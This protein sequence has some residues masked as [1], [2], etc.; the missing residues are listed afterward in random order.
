M[1]T[2]VAAA[3]MTSTAN[4]AENLDQ[5]EWLIEQA[6]AAKAKLVS[7]P[8][9]F[10]FIGLGDDAALNA[11]EAIDGATIS[12][13]QK[14][15]KKNAIWLSLGGFQEK[16]AGHNK[17]YNT[18]II[19]NNDGLL[20]ATYRKIHLFCAKLPNGAI[21]NEAK[22]VVPGQE[23]ICLDTPFFRAGLSI[24]YDVRFP[25]LYN[26]LRTRGAEVLFIPAAF[27]KLTG[28][29]HWEVLLRARAIETQCY[30]I[31]AAQFG[32]HNEQRETFGHAMIV[33][34]WGNIVAQCTKTNELAIAEIDLATLKSMRERMPM[35]Q[36]Q[37][38]F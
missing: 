20:V 34:P 13:L 25:R 6:A 26:E 33:E 23:V 30:V 27:T 7:L 1:K 38:N 4:K 16:I 15:A 9:N 18:H 24:C 5:A 22:S 36:Q 31:A 21:Y 10:A 11:A 3:Q 2:L 12:R 14:C 8:E 28:L 35:W 37:K 29:A 17:I 32:Q 19:I